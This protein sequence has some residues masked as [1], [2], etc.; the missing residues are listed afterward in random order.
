MDG[1]AELLNFIYQNSQM[2]IETISQLLKIVEDIDFS[3]QL[4]SQMN[5][6]KEINI[7]AKRLLQKSGNDEKSISAMQ[8]ISAYLM[9]NMKTMMDKSISHIAEMM[10]VGSNMGI[11]DAIK[12]IRKYEN[13]DK[14]IVALMKK[15]LKFE[16]NNVKE[17]KNY[18]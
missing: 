5:E 9:I 2:G 17:L 6:Y 13:A 3:E 10:I 8:K 16:E 14:E 12:N 4:N 7:D 11:T 15:L 1:N 18:L